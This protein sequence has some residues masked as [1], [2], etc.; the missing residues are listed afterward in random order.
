[1]AI[2]NYCHVTLQRSVNR[3]FLL[4]IG[5]NGIYNLWHFRFVASWQHEPNFSGWLEKSKTGNK[6]YC[7]VCSKYLSCS[8]ITITRHAQSSAHIWNVKQAECTPTI[9]KSMLAA[10]NT[11]NRVATAEVRLSAFIAE[12]D[13]TNIAGRTAVETSS[14]AK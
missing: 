7:G 10:N 9:S 3:L 5:G 11:Q 12:H 4:Y 1:M 6:A 8:H 13:F 14:V 2:L